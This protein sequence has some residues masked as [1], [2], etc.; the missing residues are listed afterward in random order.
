MTTQKRRIE[1]LQKWF[2]KSLCRWPLQ[3]ST[4]KQNNNPLE[5]EVSDFQNY[6]TVIQKS[7]QFSTTKILQS[8][9]RTKQ[10]RLST[11]GKKNLAETVYDEAQTL[12]LLVKGVKSREYAQ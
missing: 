8:I 12:E 9:Q 10:H 6:H 1:T 4:N 7:G 5:G 11:V 2:E 3:P